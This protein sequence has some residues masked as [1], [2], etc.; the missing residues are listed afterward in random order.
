MTEDNRSP[1]KLVVN[2]QE[3]EDLK[4]VSREGGGVLQLLAWFSAG[5]MRG[6]QGWKG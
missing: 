6:G 1:T 3:D 5:R 2:E 4:R